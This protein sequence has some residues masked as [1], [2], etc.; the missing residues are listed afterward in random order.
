LAFVAGTPNRAIGSNT[1]DIYLP[2]IVEKRGIE[3]LTAQCI[4]TS[5]ELWRKESFREFLEYRRAGLA[6]A[7]NDLLDQV[8][9]EGSRAAL[10]VASLIESGEN[11]YVEFKETARYNTQ[12]RQADKVIESMIVRAVA[13]FFN[14][15][16]GT[17]I[18]GVSDSGVVTG[19]ERDLKTLG[20]RQTL[21]GYEQFLR[22]MLNTGLGKDRCAQVKME[23]ASVDEDTVAIVN[24]PAS[25]RPVFT[26]DGKG[27][28]FY[29]RS[30]NTTQA[31]DS[32][33]AHTKEYGS[34]W[35]YELRLTCANA[36][37]RVQSSAFSLGNYIT[38]HFKQ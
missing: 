20:Q 31:L 29:A 36:L 26:R 4:P 37:R 33:R 19:L 3:A 23:F 35:I 28:N 14:A 27:V 7:V 25:D 24:V 21:D 12:T 5:P 6:T 13:G 11:H 8:V 9:Q 18:I 32:E 1:P 15:E 10:D 2:S 30:G 22:S 17:I 16:G 38:A 34:S